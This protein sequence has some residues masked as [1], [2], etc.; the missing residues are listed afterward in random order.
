MGALL[1][2][3]A[4]LAQAP[5]GPP[6]A[7]SESPVARLTA[8]DLADG[9]QLFRARCALCHGYDGTGGRGSSLAQL[10][11]RR[12]GDD[13]SLFDAIRNGIPGTEMPSVWALSDAETWRIVGYVR[14]LARSPSPPP[15]GDAE[16]GRA[17]YEGKGGCPACHVVAGKGEA[18]G[19]ELSDIGLRRGPTHL[20]EALE[21]PAAARPDGFLI[22]RVRA[23]DGSE[24]VGTRLN[25]DTFTI[26]LR[27]LEGRFH[28]FRKAELAE[29]EKQRDVSPMPAYTG[30][31][32]PAELDDLVAYMAALRGQP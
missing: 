9:Q 6:A 31:L 17:L 10:K 26:Q 1:V 24:V 8:E 4:L 14:S 11:L 20:R 18:S 22:V 15:K 27:D 2:Y 21:H 29:L 19:P 3:V 5:A 12:V 16:R 13:A 30:V 28:S 25:E 23:R 32:T 7:G